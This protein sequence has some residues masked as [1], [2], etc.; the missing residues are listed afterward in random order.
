MASKIVWPLDPH[1]AAKH[2]I[3]RRYLQA[4]YPKLGRRG[5]VLFVDGF[6]GPGVYEGGEPGSPIIALDSLTKHRY[7]PK[8]SNCEFVFLFIE[9]DVDRAQHLESLISARS[10]PPNVKADVRCGT[11]EDHMKQALDS[12]GET[13]LAPA[14]IMVDPFGV[15]GLPLDLLQRLANYPKTELLVS[16]MYEPINR[17]LSRPEFEHNLDDLFGT[18]IWRNSLGFDRDTRKEFLS[19]LYAFQLKG[20]GMEYTRFFEMRDSGNRTEYFLAFAA[21]HVAGLSAMKDAMWK[22]DESQGLRFS[23][24]TVQPEE[25]ATLFKSEPD[26]IQLYSHIEKRFAGQ[27]NVPVKKIKYFVLTATAF[28]EVHS[29]EVLRRAEK[30]KTITVMRPP[31]KRKN[32]WNAGTSVTFQS[33][34]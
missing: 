5:R 3:L 32:Y 27:R 14:F 25:Q 7:F 2:S 4:Y 29:T 28:R 26:Y 31:G 33:A 8:M 11:F 19:N 16:F 17:F 24:F 13:E 34:G 1:T 15:K 6:A 23:D 10:D 30:D 9:E 12:L 22:V 21:N 18:R 20:I